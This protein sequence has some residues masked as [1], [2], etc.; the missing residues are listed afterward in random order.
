MSLDSCRQCPRLSSFLDE[1]KAAHPAYH[2]RPVAPFGDDKPRL[3][4]VGLAPGMHGANRTGR[5]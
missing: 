3:L 5:P 2:A 1:V 4:I